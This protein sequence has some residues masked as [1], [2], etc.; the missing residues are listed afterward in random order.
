MVR[1]TFTGIVVLLSLALPSCYEP[2]HQ[3][4]PGHMMD[5]G[6]GGTIMWIGML[7]L[8]GVVIY[9]L[10]LQKGAGDQKKGEGETPLD[11]LKKRYARGEIDK[12]DFERMKKDLE[13]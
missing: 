1:V 11:I 10:W 6:Y 12:E 5:Y 8:L 7:L 13:E 3:G 2:R 9:I 4:W